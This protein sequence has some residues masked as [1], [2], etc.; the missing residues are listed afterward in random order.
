MIIRFFFFPR[1]FYPKP[2]WEAGILFYT[3]DLAF[4]LFCCQP[5]ACLI[6]GHKHKFNVFEPRVASVYPPPRRQVLRRPFL[7]LPSGLLNTTRAARNTWNTWVCSY[8]WHMDGRMA[9]TVNPPLPS[10]PSVSLPLRV[11][12][13]ADPSAC[14]SNQ[15]YPLIDYLQGSRKALMDLILNPP[16]DI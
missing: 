8:L 16:S 5:A 9:H 2:L 12:S 1:R 7:P 3:R 15:N 6:R 13:V 14:G 11:L 4:G 10:C